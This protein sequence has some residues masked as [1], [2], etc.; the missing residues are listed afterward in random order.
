M[1][2]THRKMYVYFTVETTKTLTVYILI[3]YFALNIFI[4][5]ISEMKLRKTNH[6]DKI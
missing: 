3:A 5:P 2:A 6:M 1:F 4:S